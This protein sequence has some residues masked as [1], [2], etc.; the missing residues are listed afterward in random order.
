MPTRNRRLYEKQP[1]F[2][3][4]TLF[5]VICEGEKREPAY[6]EFFDGLT[7]RIK[8]RAVGSVEGKS[9]PSHLLDNAI[10]AS[11]KYDLSSDD[12]LW[13]V[14]DID[15]WIN[16]IHDIQD[17]CATKPNWFIALSNPCFEV[18]LYYHFSAVIPEDMRSASAPPGNS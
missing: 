3:D 17:Q 2:R 18:W 12:E 14:I 10:D 9:A 15:R 5:V 4:A 6:F 7:S 1:P 13:F 11:R 16:H 8:V